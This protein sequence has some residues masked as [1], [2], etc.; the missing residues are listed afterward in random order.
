MLT[1]CT[2]R[3]VRN[4]QFPDGSHY[5]RPHV[6]EQ[7]GYQFFFSLLESCFAFHSSTIFA[8]HYTIAGA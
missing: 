5:V 4:H 3:A 7:A 2:N 8:K 1:I 6:C